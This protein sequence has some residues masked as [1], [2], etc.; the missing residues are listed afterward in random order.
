MAARR[1]KSAPH[2]AAAWGVAQAGNTQLRLRPRLYRGGE[3]AF[4]PG[5]AALLDAIA[6]TG[7]IRQAAAEL[8]MSYMRAWTLVRTMNACFAAPLVAAERGGASG[9]VARLTPDGQRVLE[10]YC[11]IAAESLRAAAPAWKK[12]RKLLRP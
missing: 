8:D 1:R 3:I 9:G 10:L 12:L 11:D 7:S 2:P 5:K 4:G 6:R